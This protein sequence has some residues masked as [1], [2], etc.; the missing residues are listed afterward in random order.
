MLKNWIDYRNIQTTEAGVTALFSDYLS[1]FEKVGCYYAGAYQGRDAWQAAIRRTLT[2]P[3]DRSLL[4]RVLTDQN[5]E[6]LCGVKTLANIDLLGRDNTLALVTG[7][8][9][10]ML[11]GPLYTI[12]K[13]ITAIKLAESLAIE[14]PEYNFVPVFWIEGEDHD[15][16]EI[17]NATVLNQSHEIAT[18]E[19][20]LGGRPLERNP[21]PVGAIV[22]DESI[23]QFFDQ[24]GMQLSETEFKKPLL[25]MLR[26]HYRTGTSMG[27]AFAGLMS[28]YFGDTGLILIDPS[29]SEL[30]RH[31][32]SLFAAEISSIS[33]TSQ[34]VIEQSAELEESYH[35]QIKAKS[36]NLFMHHK[37][38]RYLIEPREHDFSL[39]G[40]RQYFSKEDLQR[41]VDETPELLSPNVVLRPV[42]QDFLLP[43][44]AYVGGPSEI[45]YFAQLKTVY[46]RFGV[47]MPVIYPRASVTIVE[48]RINDILE[49]FQVE[50]EE[51]FSSLDPV[52]MRI[53]EQVSEVKVEALFEQLMV[54]FREA[55]TEARFGIQQ[56][57]PTLSGTVDALLSK[58]EA[59]INVLQDKTQKA[60]Q[61]RQEVSLRQI[62]KAASLLFPKG[63]FQERVFSTAYFLNKYG[64]DFIQWLMP[65]VSIDKFQ[66]QIIL[67]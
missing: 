2:L 53:A 8:Q 33:K 40:T 6:F 63:N 65:E 58:T 64:P 5:R 39:K 42:Y 54:R 44:V 20:L 19:Y 28:S 46:E 36:V 25:E 67:V 11:T 48:E 30:K 57:D 38:G 61:R 35:A 10:G 59:N 37:G 66:H 14:H 29:H 52:L 41:I 26:A 21:G 50:A 45:A 9:V 27:R 43:T 3:R 56:I 12:Y 60:Q 15:F 13:T 32:R 16:A 47:P 23:D 18:I 62:H 22:I 31:A 34:L 1:N 55:V 49:R 17:N 7:Q 24:L 4:Q 51:M